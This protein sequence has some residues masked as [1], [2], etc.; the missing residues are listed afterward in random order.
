MLNFE[1]Y[2]VVDCM[3]WVF[4]SNGS[5]SYRPSCNMSENVESCV[6]LSNADILRTRG[7]FRCGRL[8]FF[9][10][11]SSDFLKFV[12]CPHG[13][14]RGW[15]SADILWTRGGVNFSRLNFVKT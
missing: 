9:V 11:K 4:D 7:F 3:E 2:I 13:Q 12:V 1:W 15:A 5:L 8:H 6:T 10:Q 14:G